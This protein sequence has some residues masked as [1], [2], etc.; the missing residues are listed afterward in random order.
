MFAACMNGVTL[1]LMDAG[2]PLSGALTAVTCA[3]LPPAGSG[4]LVCACL[5]QHR[6]GLELLAPFESMWCV[7]LF[8][9]VLVFISAHVCM[10]DYHIA[11]NF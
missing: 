10:Y 3:L 4:T 6:P 11:V 2:V 9:G 1:A 5:Y 7:R 8:A